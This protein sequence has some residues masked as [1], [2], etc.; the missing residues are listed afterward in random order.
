M[1]YPRTRQKIARVGVLKTV[2]DLALTTKPSEGFGILV[3]GGFADLTAE[4]LVIRHAHRFAED[5]VS[6]ARARLELAGV[7]LP[8]EAS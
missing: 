2:G 1:A 6:G 4:Y 5:V 7:A 3:E 8:P